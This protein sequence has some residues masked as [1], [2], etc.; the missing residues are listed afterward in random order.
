MG[1]QVITAISTPFQR[2]FNAIL[3]PFLRIQIVAAEGQDH[4]TI[5]VAAALEAAGVARWCSPANP[6]FL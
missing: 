6:A 4:R 1:I 5:A 2:H 3:K